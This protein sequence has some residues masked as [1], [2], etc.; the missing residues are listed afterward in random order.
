MKI[1]DT[2]LLSTVYYP[3]AVELV[4]SVYPNLSNNK[5]AK[6]ATKICQEMVDR[7]IESIK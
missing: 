3:Q 4:N 7:H 6:M 1:I 2:I 5:K